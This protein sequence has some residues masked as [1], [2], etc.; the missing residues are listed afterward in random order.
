MACDPKGDIF[1]LASIGPRAR[2]TVVVRAPRRPG[3]ASRR[4]PPP[5]PSSRRRPAAR[6]EQGDE[7]L[8]A[9]AQRARAG[10]GGVR[11]HAAAHGDGEE[12]SR[13]AAA[14]DGGRVGGGGGGGGGHSLSLP[15]SSPSALLGSLL[16]ATTTINRDTLPLISRSTGRT[17]RSAAKERRGRTKART[18]RARSLASLPSLLFPPN[19]TTVARR[20]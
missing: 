16:Y 3:A 7:G 18:K 9:T 12:I 8:G 2:V 10:S 11:A 6:E 20:G 14:R 19:P 15:S 13:C 17:T 1:P 5:P 4:L